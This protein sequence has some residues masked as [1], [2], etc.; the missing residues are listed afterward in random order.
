MEKLTDLLLNAE[1]DL[2][3]DAE[4]LARLKTRYPGFDFVR[5]E[6]DEGS[7]I[8]TFAK[9]SRSSNP[10]LEEAIVD[11]LQVEHDVQ[12]TSR[13]L[14]KVLA[15]YAGLLPQ[16]EDTAMNAIGFALIAL[17]ERKAILRIHEGRGRDPHRYMAI[18]SEDVSANEKETTDM[19]P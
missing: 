11:R 10:E 14:Y 9:T 4:E 6:M 1:R 15:N 5:M 3:R 12:W 13:T 8:Q 17:T 7:R 2:K 16:R 19:V 18:P